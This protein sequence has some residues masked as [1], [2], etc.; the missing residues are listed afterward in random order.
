MAGPQKSKLIMFFIT[1][2]PV[3]IQTGQHTEHEV[4]I[5]SVKRSEM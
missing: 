1:K 3:I 2:M 5:G 4:A